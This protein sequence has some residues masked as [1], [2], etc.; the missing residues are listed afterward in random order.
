MNSRGAVRKKDR[1]TVVGPWF[2]MPI[3]FL[4]SRACAELSPHGVKMFLDLCSCLGPNARGNG[5][6]SAAPGIMRPRGWT[7]TATR[8]A[9]LK[10]L[11]N[12]ELLTVTK[13][14]NRQAPTLYAITL[15]PLS[16]D[17]SKLEH[18]P[19]SYSS[20]DWRR[21]GG[22][23][24]E[25]PTGEKPAVW[26]ALRKSENGLPARGQRRAV[27]TPAR[28]QMPATASGVVPPAGT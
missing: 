9:A 8:V 12:A 19:G 28:E 20:S 23:R 1:V 13:H 11:E 18:G 3:E 14:G 17:L 7:S 25:R 6:L 5:D 4:R 15:W 2:P 26:A 24:E 22:D 21:S 27:K 10:E 16:C